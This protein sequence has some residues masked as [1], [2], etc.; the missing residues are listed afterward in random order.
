MLSR[1]SAIERVD[2]VCHRDHTLIAHRDEQAQ[3]NGMG[4]GE[5]QHGACQ[6]SALQHHADRAGVQRR[7]DGQAIGSNAICYVNETVAVRTKE[8][9]STLLRERKQVMLKLRSFRAHLAEA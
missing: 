3:P 1:K 8:R 6:C 5:G 9:Q 2:Y 7:R 4:L